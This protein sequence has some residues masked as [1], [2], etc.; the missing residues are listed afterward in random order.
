[1]LHHA[2]MDAPRL[3]ICGWMSGKIPTPSKNQTTRL[4]TESAKGILKGPSESPGMSATLVHPLS[5]SP[6]AIDGRDQGRLDA[7][8]LANLS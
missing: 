8:H 4:K 3:L 5:S 2:T 1:M 6:A 7:L